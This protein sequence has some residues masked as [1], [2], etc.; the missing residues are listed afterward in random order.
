MTM[1]RFGTLMVKIA[2][3]TDLELDRLASLCYLPVNRPAP[4]TSIKTFD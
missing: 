1:T 4:I 2:F 3:K